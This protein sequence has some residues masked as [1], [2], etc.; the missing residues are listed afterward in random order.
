LWVVN[1]DVILLLGIIVISSNFIVGSSCS[2]GKG[3]KWTTMNGILI[4]TKKLNVLFVAD[5]WQRRV[6]VR[7]QKNGNEGPFLTDIA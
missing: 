5:F 4:L 3:T 7:C 1:R 2:E 6:A